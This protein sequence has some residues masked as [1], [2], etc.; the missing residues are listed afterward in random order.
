MVALPLT[1]LGSAA[2]LV[3]LRSVIVCFGRECRSFVIRA[4]TV[5]ECSIEKRVMSSATLQD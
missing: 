5:G 1:V 4:L 2:E 3:I